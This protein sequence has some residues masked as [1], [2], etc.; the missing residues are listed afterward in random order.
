MAQSNLYNGQS[1]S[2]SLRL[3]IDLLFQ[4]I[5]IAKQDQPAQKSL[6]YHIPTSVIVRRIFKL[7]RVYIGHSVLALASIPA[8]KAR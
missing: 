6:S 4:M 5:S 7:T 8:I 2:L 1:K 3:C